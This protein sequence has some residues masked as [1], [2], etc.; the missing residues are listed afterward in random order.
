[1]HSDNSLQIK[2]DLFQDLYVLTA[3]GDVDLSNHRV[4]GRILDQLDDALSLILD[5]RDIRYLDSSVID[6]LLRS[7]DSHAATGAHLA[8]VASPVVHGIYS[9][10]GLD[11]RMTYYSDIA[12]AFAHFGVDQ[13]RR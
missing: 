9:G 2:L 3:Q 1:M 7:C 13:R 4:F 10:L 6:L 8:L 5:F 12:L 11:A